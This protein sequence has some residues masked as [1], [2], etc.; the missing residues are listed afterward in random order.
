MSEK[1]E[2]KLRTNIPEADKY[3]YKPKYI[4]YH[5]DTKSI[6]NVGWI[7][8]NDTMV[9]KD[10]QLNSYVNI[11]DKK[12]VETDVK[13]DVFVKDSIKFFHYKI[14]K[15]N[16]ISYELLFV[17]G[18]GELIKFDYSVQSKEYNNI[19]NSIE[20]SIGSIKLL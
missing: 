7:I 15:P 9:T 14:V 19:R 4:Y 10:Q 18:V 16:L 3:I 6:M 8:V 13:K 17:N 1:S 2:W 12:Y 20:S 11:L 5:N